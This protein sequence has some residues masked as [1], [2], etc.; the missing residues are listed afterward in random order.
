ML[1]IATQ[2]VEHELRFERVVDDALYARIEA[3]KI[4]L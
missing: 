4:R 3:G 2:R 1:D